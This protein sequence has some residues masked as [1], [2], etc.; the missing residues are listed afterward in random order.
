MTYGRQKK[1]SLKG[2]YPILKGP[3][4]SIVIF[5][6]WSL[7][8]ETNGC[9]LFYVPFQIFSSAKL[10]FI[11]GLTITSLLFSSQITS[12]SQQFKLA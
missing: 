11:L 10:I 3:N 4:I 1:M 2:Q 6:I 7:I 9:H 8:E 12:Q 5:L